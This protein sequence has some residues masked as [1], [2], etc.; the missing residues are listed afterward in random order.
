MFVQIIQG[1]TEDRAGIRR[2][3]DRWAEQLLPG[4]DGFL[5]S[6]AGVSDDGELVIVARF[7]TED[8]A[9]RN[10]ARPEQGHWWEELS[11]HLTGPAEFHDSTEVEL[12]REGGSD[13]AGFVQVL[14]ARAR[15]PDRVRELDAQEEEWIARYRPDVIGGLTA[16]HD[17]GLFTRVV[18]FTSERDA[19]VGERRMNTDVPDDVRERL[20][21][22]RSLIEGLT[23]TDLHDPWTFSA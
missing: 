20:E 15:D 13:E 22:W 17:G 10:S 19:R 14:R 2:L 4:A 8:A 16:W 11:G 18:Y 7:D 21:E 23:Y 3:L 1:R 6:T 12:I 9:R 5:G